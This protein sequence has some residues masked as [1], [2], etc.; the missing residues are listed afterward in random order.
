MNSKDRAHQ[1]GVLAVITGA[2]TGLVVAGFERLVNN[3]LLER[4]LRAPLWVQAIGPAAGLTLAAVALHRLARDA[5]PSTSDE[6]IRAFHDTDHPLELRPVPGRVVASIATLGAGAPMGFEGP[7]IYMGAAIGTWL[8][9]RF[10]RYFAPVDSKVL[11]VCGAAAGVAAIFKAPVTGVVFALEVPYREDLARRML[12]PAMFAAAASYLVYVALNGTAPLF[13][14]AGTPPFDLRDLLG[15]AALG[16]ACGAGAHGFARLVLVAKQLAVRVPIAIRLPLA[17]LGIAALFVAG[18]ALTG[19]SLV[20]GPG[21][22][23]IDWALEP[24]H[25]LAVIV[26]LFAIR[27]LATILAVGGGGA[28][29]LFVPLVVQGALAGAATGALVHV[30]AESAS[31][32]PLLGVAAFLGAGYRVPLAAVVFV[33]ESTGRPGFV[34]P[35]L[36]AAACSQLLMGPWS[37]TPYQRTE[38]AGMLEHRLRLPISSALRTDAVTVPSDATVSDVFEHHIGELRL[39][40]IPV[41][42]GAA[43]RGL[44]TLDDV[45]RLPRAEWDTTEVRAV[46]RTEVDTGSLDWTLERAV[47]VMESADTD[48]LVVLDRGMF[49]GMVT[50]GE[51]LKLDAIL[52]RAEQPDFGRSSKSV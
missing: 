41:V 1:I 5:S 8:Q 13:P 21:Y 42:D 47:S 7:S 39:R 14:V 44:V 25:A 28:G 24:G 6:Y 46:M 16:L 17:G 52:D 32:F 45:A 19:E 31:L 23:T 22:S 51:I 11:L 35:G 9:R 48:R 50:T 10:G 30:P 15:A 4:L 33:A 38:R 37:V 34:V 26:A 20:I 43:F 40:T 49:V 2:I 3:G 36:I 27:G 29:G 18:R 12:L